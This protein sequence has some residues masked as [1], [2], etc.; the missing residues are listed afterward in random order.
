M[1]QH[2]I[3][4]FKNQWLQS[5]ECA[6]K[7]LI[8]YIKKKQ[9]MRDTQISAIE[10]YLFLKIKAKNKPLWQLIAEG[11]FG[12]DTSIIDRPNIYTWTSEKL[13]VLNNNHSA[14]H[15][16]NFA[17]INLQ[18]LADNPNLP[19]K[20]IMP[21]LIKHIENNILNIDFDKLTQQLFYGNL[22]TDYLFSLPMGAG[23]TYLMAAFIYLDLYFA[24]LD[25]DNPLFAHNFIIVVPSGLK[26]SILPSLKTIEKFDPTWVIDNPAATQLKN[27]LQFEVLDEIKGSTKEQRRTNPNAKKVSARQPFEAMKGLVM[28]VNA[29]KVILDRLE[30]NTNGQLIERTLDEKQQQ[31]NELRYLIGKIPHLQIHVDEVHHAAT[32]DIKLRQVISHWN[33]Q[34]AI[35]SVLGYSGTPYLRT[36]DKIKLDDAL[37]IRSTQITN[38]VYYYPLKTAI[39]HFLKKPT[40]V[41]LTRL[42]PLE[43]IK[44]GVTDFMTKYAD[45]VYPNGTCAKLAIY[46]SSIEKLEEHIYPLLLGEL[47]IEPNLILKYH[48]GNAK[49]KLSAQNDTE[50]ASLDMPFSQKKIVLLVQ[51]GKEGWDC[52]SLTGVILSQKGDCPTNMVLQT[53]CRCL[54]Q[55]TPNAT[56]ETALIYL[57]EENA[58]ELDKQLKNEQQ[59]SIADINKLNPNDTPIE[60]QRFARI[61]HLKLPPIDFY[62]LRIT[63]TIADNLLEEPNPTLKI[64]QLQTEKYKQTIQRTEKYS[65]EANAPKNKQFIDTIIDQPA[66]F[67]QWLMCIVKESF[68]TLTYNDLQPF[69]PQLNILFD[70][71]TETYNNIRYFNKV[72]DRQKIQA[73]IRLAFYQQRHFEYNAEI[74]S[75]TAQWLI[76]Q[77]LTPIAEN[78]RLYPSE[79]ETQKILAADK[80]P[81]QQQ[82]NDPQAIQKS[83][84]EVI[85][86]MEKQGFLNYEL[87]YTLQQHINAVTPS[88]EV[89]A[90]EHTFHFLPYNFQQ[91][92][93]EQKVLIE[94]L[95][96]QVFKKLNLEI[97]YNGE[98]HLTEFSIDCYR[99]INHNYVKIG[100]Y[101]PDFLIIQRNNTQNKSDIYK[102]LILETKGKGFAEQPA[103]LYR[104]EF[105]E[106]D[107]LRLNNEKFNYK[108]FDFILL[109][110]T[111]K[112]AESIKIL[113]DKITDFFDT[114]I[115]P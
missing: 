27:M 93:F 18:K 9:K 49:H 34:G 89:A 115:N 30:L 42:E 64:E 39:T 48:K 15:L 35:N 54:R 56:D 3:E 41:E 108:R 43:I 50:F 40:I 37:Q 92:S 8:A 103:F 31:A 28:V 67:D 17:S 69:I 36:P 44:Q 102:I 68:N 60:R 71:I 73:D 16:L 99:K 94:I 98:R 66:H 53:S 72:Y 95:D 55:V 96:Q 11:F 112:P 1:F 110:E 114:Q 76:I 104:K 79:T 47:K 22:Y 57:N 25:P 100:Q 77:K 24:E 74:V 84:Q 19:N 5:D 111:S 45:K 106:T 61:E 107:F 90:K 7:P 52:K 97:Y 81:T 51:V 2:I 23:K 82:T 10:T 29:E 75:Q 21:E 78:N 65:F 87:N 6:I 33:Q 109:E 58:K 26:S 14:L 13:D 59:T 88:R 91:S 85:S 83:Y 20:P 80:N 63:Y 32:D 46:C 113:T 4:H 105:I 62:Q 101:T 12:L 70:Q 86:L 38:T